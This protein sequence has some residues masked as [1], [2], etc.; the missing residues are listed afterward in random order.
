MTGK[1]PIEASWG[2]IWIKELEDDPSSSR[3]QDPPAS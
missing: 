2:G 3:D 1:A